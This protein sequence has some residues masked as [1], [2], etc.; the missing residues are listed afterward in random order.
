MAAE[1]EKA[2][3]DIEELQARSLTYSRDTPYIPH[4]DQ[5]PVEALRR[6]NEELIYNLARLERE[7]GDA[8]EQVRAV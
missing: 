3:R 2:R 8:Q 1:L 4:D 5:D 7:L 6:Q